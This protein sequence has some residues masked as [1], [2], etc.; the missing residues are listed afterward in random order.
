MFR[1]VC[2]TLGHRFAILFLV[3][4]LVSLPKIACAAGSATVVA[5]HGVVATDEAEC[6]RIGRDI[7]R[8]GGHAVDAAVA[9]TLCLGVVNP[10]HS[11]LGG[12]GFMLVRS[13]SGHAKVFDMR[14]MA[15]GQASKI[16]KILSSYG[17]TGVPVWLEMHRFIEALK[18]ALALR[19]NLGDPAFVNVTSVLQ[20][21]IS[22]SF[23][24]S[25]K[26]R[27]NDNKTFDSAHYGSKWNQVYDQGTTHICVVDDQRNVVT[28]TTSLNS[29]FGS[30][31]MSPSTGIFL[32]NQMCDFSVTSSHER[33]PSPANFVQPFKRPLSSMA[34][35]ILVKGKQVKA[36]I[37]AAGGILIPDA[38]TQVLINH[39]IL[40]MDPF[41]AV[42][43]PRLY[44]LLYP[45]VVFHEKF[46]T[47]TGRYEYKPEVLNEL[48]KRGHLLRECSSWTICQFVIQKLSGPDSGKLVAV[49]DP[50]K[51]GAPAGY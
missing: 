2:P 7:L 40:K 16:L 49:S 25:L 31:F 20:T 27:I 33:P 22:T 18:Y 4:F 6:S 15:P 44:H 8:Q 50:R 1:R 13:S 19:M 34:P 29:N 14:E 28:M 30:K 42:R 26:D 51:G 5:R 41:T 46:R 36:V 24:K 17:T 43:I 35:T 37:G 21:M 12:G 48:K 3:L 45:D 47:K 32:N 11:G 23:A 39:F 9:A 10:A 38:V